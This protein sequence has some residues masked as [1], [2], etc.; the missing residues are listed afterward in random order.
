MLD[1]RVLKNRSFSIINC[2]MPNCL[3]QR[4]FYKLKI[5]VMPCKIKA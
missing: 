5:F 1:Y 4:A 2:H 3:L